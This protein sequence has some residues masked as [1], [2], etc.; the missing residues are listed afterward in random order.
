MG[1]QMKNSSSMNISF[2]GDVS[3]SNGLNGS[4]SGQALMKLF[5]KKRSVKGD[6]SSFLGGNNSLIKEN[7]GGTSTIWPE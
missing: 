4:T 5:G 7:L 2:M 6:E 1:S 3:S